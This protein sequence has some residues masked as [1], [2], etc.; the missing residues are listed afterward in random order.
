MRKVKRASPSVQQ[1]VCQRMLQG[2]QS[3]SSPNYAI[4]LFTL[5][6]QAKEHRR[7]QLPHQPDG[8][9]LAWRHM[10]TEQLGLHFGCGIGLYFAT[11]KW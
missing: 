6:G 2:A 10:T 9:P 3:Q 1:V 4:H 5:C 7:Q 8:Q 11:L